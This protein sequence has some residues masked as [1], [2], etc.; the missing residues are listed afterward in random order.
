METIAELE[1]VPEAPRAGVLLHH[2]LRLQILSR[3]H[4]P[5]SATEI[6]ADL[7]VPRQKVNYHVHELARARFLVKAGRRRKRNLYEQRWVASARSYV[8]AP[9]VLGPVVADR[10]K[11][12]DKLSAAYLLAL[13]AQMQSELGNALGEA[14]NQGK[15]LSTLA[16]EAELR[17]TSAAQ[18]QRFT[19]AL[20]GAI[21][22]VV[23][24]HTSP[25]VQ[26][27]GTPG[28]GRPFRLAL[29]CYPIPPEST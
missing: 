2:P 28:P 7:D 29:G 14:T 11:V 13:G 19:S 24:E 22:Q 26:P 21:E 4:S 3:A 17:F 25:A 10:G 8:L 6:A 23:A 15:R 9:E 12:E 18:R 1:S 27:D 16:V 5:H 20:R